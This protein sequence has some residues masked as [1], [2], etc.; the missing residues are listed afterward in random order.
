MKRS[1]CLASLAVPC[2]V[3]LAPFVTSEVGAQS[4]I[5]DDRVADALS[6]I[7]RDS[8]GAVISRA[9]VTLRL[10]PA[11]LARVITGRADG[12]FSLAKTAAGRYSVTVS[13][14]GFTPVTRFIDVP[15]AESL[16]F[17]L[18]PAAIVEQVT[19]VSASRET[20]LRET[21][22]TRVDVV[23]RS[24]IEESGGQET[25]GEILRELPGVLTRRGSETAGAAGEQIQGIDSREVL[26]LLDGQPI[27]AARGI[28][29]GG[30]LI[31]DRQSTARLER[32]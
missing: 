8:T 16:T 12:T 20:E 31:L 14:P 26:V 1:L 29:R 2:V 3:L 25:V 28:K 19:V 22:N 7:V 15:G 13:A 23:S 18:E 4:A 30:L 32:V 17:T 10:E 27:A 9:T 5:V 24:R 11:G 6:G 21:L